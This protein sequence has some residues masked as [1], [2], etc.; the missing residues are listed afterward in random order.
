MTRARYVVLDTN[1]LYRFVTQG[2]EGCEEKHWNELKECVASNKV[3]MVV[4]EV[5]LLE[6]EKKVKEMLDS[7]SAVT[8]RVTEAIKK[9]DV[10]WNECQS[11]TTDLIEETKA[12]GSRWKEN[13]Y[14][15]IA[16]VRLTMQSEII[17]HIPFDESIA[18]RTK[19][20]VI[21][22]TIKDLQD[23]DSFIIES[24]RDYFA[25]KAADLLFCTED[26]GM[27]LETK[28]SH[29]T[30]HPKFTDDVTSNFPP[31]IVHTSLAELI[32]FIKSGKGVDR[33][34][35]EEVQEELQ[36]EEEEKI[37]RSLLR[38]RFNKFLRTFSDWIAIP[39][40][41]KIDRLN[42]MMEVRL[43]LRHFD[44][45]LRND[46]EAIDSHQSMLEYYVWRE[47]L[48]RVGL[49]ID[50]MGPLTDQEWKL[51]QQ[52]VETALEE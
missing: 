40:S 35:K 9:I 28:D 37:H 22:G 44:F 20:R 51:F 1:I 13:A 48:K 32:D 17:D 39:D 30:I 8:S 49:D 36:R 11:I 7:L 10:G 34:K 24:L 33:P 45:K 4:P 15:R 52:M 18:L 47:A 2:K 21:S 6:F 31:S 12:W 42:R 23:N 29:K 41:N 50:G 16:E 43:L 19:K 46:L 5:V 3:K 27:A 25:E 26:S 14:R 38:A